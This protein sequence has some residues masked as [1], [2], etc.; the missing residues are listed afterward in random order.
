MTFD[1]QAL[2]HRAVAVADRDELDIR[3]EKR[4][5]IM[6]AAATAL[7]VMIVASIAVLL[8]MA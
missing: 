4:E 1:S 2:S 7:A 8:G 6:M 5:R 3:A